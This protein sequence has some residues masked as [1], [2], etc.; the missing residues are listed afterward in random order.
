MNKWIYI[1]APLIVCFALQ[2]ITPLSK[3]GSVVKFRPPAFTFGIIWTIL[4]L[5]FGYAWSL[6]I[7]NS[8]WFSLTMLLLA[9]WI[10]IYG[11]SSKWASWILV[12]L[13]ASILACMSVGNEKTKLLLS[14]LLAWTIFATIMNTTEVQYIH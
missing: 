1:L 12:L 7:K 14:P 13:M 2:Y 4:F 8:E 9:L 3:A 6:N 10:V 11:K 5:M